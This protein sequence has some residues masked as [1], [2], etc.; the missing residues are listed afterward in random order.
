MLK[1]D[2]LKLWERI[3]ADDTFA[4]KELHDRYYYLLHLY[5]RK[6]F[7]HEEEIEEAISDC[8]ITLWNK[9][10]ELFIA[11]SLKSY[12]CLMVRNNLI[13]QQRKK[14]PIAFYEIQ[15]IDLPDFE[16][17]QD[18]QRYAC[19]Y[20]ALEKIPEQRRKILELAVFDSLSYDQIA[21]KLNISVNT[22]KTQMGRA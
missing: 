2:D 7:H 3:R 21:K 19:L 10:K 17:E 22:V 16:S 8:F 4:L 18:L 9:R 6:M 5:A 13:D 14:K 11:K 12:L 15:S 20:N 1:E